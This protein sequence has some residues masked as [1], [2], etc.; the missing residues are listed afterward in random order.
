MPASLASVYLHPRFFS[1]LG[2]GTKR[3][4]EGRDSFWGEVHKVASSSSGDPL[5][6]PDCPP[7]LKKTDTWEKIAK[8][9]K[10]YCATTAATI[11][12]RLKKP[13]SWMQKI[14]ESIAAAGDLTTLFR[15]RS[16]RDDL[17]SVTYILEA[18]LERVLKESDTSS[19]KRRQAIALLNLKLISERAF[20]E[21]DGIEMLEIF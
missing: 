17:E 11:D 6:D 10:Q 1:S 2:G 20:F 14:A 19:L 5:E 7:L 8:T 9:T 12:E 18:E 4:F 16:F 3:P 15:S 13:A 21:A